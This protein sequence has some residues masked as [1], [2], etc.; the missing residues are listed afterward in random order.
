MVSCIGGKFF[1]HFYYMKVLHIS[2]EC[3]PAAKVGGLADVVGALPKHLQQLGVS[4]SVVIPKYNTSW[5]TSASYST[6][7]K[8]SAKMHLTYHSF[9]IEQVASIELG[10]N[11]FVVNLPEMFDREGIYLDRSGQGYTDHVERFLAFQIAVL[12]W[13][14]NTPSYVDLIHCHDHHSGFIPFLLKHGIVYK[15]L[16]K[17]P[18]IF[19]VH[20]A[21]YHGSFSWEKLYLLPWFDH[22]ER[23]ML[24]WNHLIDPLAVGIKTAWRVTTVSPNYLEELKNGENGLEWLFQHEQH[25]SKGILNGIDQSVWNPKL[26]NLLSFQLIDDDWDTFK[27]KNKS[28]LQTYFGLEPGLPIVTFIGRLAREKGAD[29]LPDLIKKI[30]TSGVDVAMVVLGTGDQMIMD[31]LLIHKHRF[32]GRFATAL[33]Y[34][35]PL[36]HQLYAGSDFLLMPSRIEPCGLNQ[37]YAMRYGTM[38]IVREVGGLKDTVIDMDHSEIQGS[39]ITFEHF[40]LEDSYEAV[41]R[42]VKLYFQQKD[43]FEQI[44]NYITTIDHSWEAS[45][46]TYLEIYEELTMVE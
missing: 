11:L 31:Q 10:F 45:A 41:Q 44:R 19:T 17:I 13:L 42:A 2:A 7:Y 46:N 36:A 28:V 20:N 35:E 22:E 25:K 32:E 6:I 23:Q 9:T 30:M 27:S 43:Q 1:F 26:D 15:S 34:N 21:A 8:G 5:L 14:V 39:G 12:E 38:P 16:S 4:S 29:L 18:T 37:M 33:E 3:F 24:D 40:N